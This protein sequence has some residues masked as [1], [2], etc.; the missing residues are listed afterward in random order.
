[1]YTSALFTAILAGTA[2]MSLCP[3]LPVQVCAR[4]NLSRPPPR[5]GA[6]QA[7]DLDQRHHPRRMPGNLYLHSPNL[8]RLSLW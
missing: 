1:M 6:R 8:Q 5:P 7:T 3:S 4:A 2:R